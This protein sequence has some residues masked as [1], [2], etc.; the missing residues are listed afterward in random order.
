VKEKKMRTEREIVRT[1][2]RKAVGRLEGKTHEMKQ[3]AE[4]DQEEDKRKRTRI[5]AEK[6]RRGRI[7]S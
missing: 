3:K 1:S 4:E 6:S 5:V 7:R 2:E